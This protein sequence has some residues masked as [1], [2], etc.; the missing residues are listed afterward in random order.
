MRELWKDTMK[1]LQKIFEDIGADAKVIDASRILRLPHSINRKAKY[2][3]EGKRVSVVYENDASYELNDL[4]QKL[5]FMADGGTEGLLEDVLEKMD[6]I[7]FA[8]AVDE[9]TMFIPVDVSE[10]D[11]VFKDVK[12]E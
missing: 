4:N 10:E 3:P 12:D 9:E 1:S 7:T 2:G 6:D 5:R 8:G 11:D